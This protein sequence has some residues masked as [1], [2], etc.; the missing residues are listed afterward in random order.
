MKLAR[1]AG[2][3][4]SELGIAPEMIEA[5]E[6]VYRAWEAENLGGEFACAA[7]SLAIRR[8]LTSLWGLRLDE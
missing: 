7:S 2:A 5:G 8:L 4:E 3:H 6:R 1:Q